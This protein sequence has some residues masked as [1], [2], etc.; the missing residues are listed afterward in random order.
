MTEKLM[1]TFHQSERMASINGHDASIGFKAFLDTTDYRLPLSNYMTV[2]QGT[3]VQM[4]DLERDRASL[5][6]LAR[7]LHRSWKTGDPTYADEARIGLTVGAEAAV[8]AAEDK[9]WE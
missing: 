2:L 7:A 4:E 9:E 1:T 8:K 6:A 3:V 5:V